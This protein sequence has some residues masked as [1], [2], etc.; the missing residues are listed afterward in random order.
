M[1]KK[2]FWVGTLSLV[3]VFG[4][5]IITSC[6]TLIAQKVTEPI[7]YTELI[8]VPGMSQT[9]VF[10]SAKMYFDAAFRESGYSS[11]QVSDQDSGIIKGKL[12][13]DGFPR[14]DYLYRYN[15]TF[16]VEAR[17]D[18]CRITFTEPTIQDIGFAS[19]QAKEMAFQGYLMGYKG[20]LSAMSPLTSKVMMPSN[21]K[22]N[23]T[24]DELRAEWESNNP[25]SSNPGPER[26]AQYDYQA[27]NFRGEWIKLAAQLKRSITAN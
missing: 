25:S 14:G 7:T 11:I 20:S 24:D 6:S 12:A 9:E 1:A 21:S 17:D 18:S 19:P 16:T 22:L 10:T 23:Q 2:N 3:L 4:M 8:Q 26:P 27:E 15:S 5:A 13:I